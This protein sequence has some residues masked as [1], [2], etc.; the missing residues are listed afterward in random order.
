[1][2]P[3]STFCQSPSHVWL[4]A[5]VLLL[6]ATAIAHAA[7]SK[8]L[9][10][11]KAING[12]SLVITTDGGSE[13]TIAL[14]AS[15]RILKVLPGQA[16]KNATPIQPSDIKVGDRVLAAGQPGDANATVATT[17]VV[18]KQTDIA[19]KQQQE[20]E[21][22]RRGV[23]GIVKE[24]NATAGTIT[25]AN[26]LASGGKP[27]L[28]HVSSAT[29][30]RRYSPDS[31]K[32]DDAKPGTLDEIKPGDQLRARGD[33]NAD[34]TEFTAQAIVSGT[35]KEIAGT[36]ISTDAAGGNLTVMDLVSKKPV[37]LRVT[38]D[39]QMH[40]L[41]QFV[42]QR[43][44]MR[45]K[46]RTPPSNGAPA[47]TTGGNGVPSGAAQSGAGAGRQWQGQGSSRAAGGS[48]PPPGGTGFS[49]GGPL[50]FQQILS[51]MPSVS[52]SDLQK[53][54]AIMLV[55][56]AGSGTSAPTTITLLSGVEP[57]LTA[58]PS[59]AAAAMMLSPW[60]LGAS[61]GGDAASE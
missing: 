33:K 61:P 51:R 59:G 48:G 53:G 25:V 22:W 10:T 12:T 24:V 50:D 6:F 26:A 37:T 56:T 1:M 13:A 3:L 5:A 17:V 32:F 44:A 42:A 49:G 20:R 60:N 40:K 8:V 47:N 29:L 19:D 55:A 58:A 45:V 2:K 28:I 11:V 41:P 52:L 21:A 7:S 27:V 38:A 9:G 54:D 34:G 23:G 39:S 36:V 57:I 16:I 30:I 15:T 35:F 18:M 43:L 31:V 46:G 4:R 14:T